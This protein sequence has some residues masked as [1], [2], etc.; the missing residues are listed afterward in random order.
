MWVLGKVGED[1][2]TDEETERAEEPIMID[3][4]CGEGSG[5]GIGGR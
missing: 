4:D 5:G 1:Y 3:S 2:T